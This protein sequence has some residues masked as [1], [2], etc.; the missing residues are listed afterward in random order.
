MPSLGSGMGL[1][2]AGYL[3]PKRPEKQIAGNSLG[4]PRSPQLSRGQLIAVI[5]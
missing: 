1:G 5:M 4:F 3:T 2:V